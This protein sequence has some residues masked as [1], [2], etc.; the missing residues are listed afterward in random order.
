MSGQTPRVD[1]FDNRNILLRQPI[2]QGS[3]R[4]PIGIVLRKFSDDDSID[5]GLL[6]LE[7]LGVDAVIADHWSGHDHDLPQ[8]RRI[9]EDLLIT[10]EVGSEHDF[11]WGDTKKMARGS[12]E[13]RAIFK[14]Y[15]RWLLVAAH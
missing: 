13:P 11:P 15:V 10:A 14:Q 3:S 1:A 8:I 4:A 9:R 7:I 2:T 5:L 6:G 12:G